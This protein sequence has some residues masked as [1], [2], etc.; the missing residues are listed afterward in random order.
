MFLSFG[1]RNVKV[2]N[3]GLKKWLREGRK[4]IP[5]RS[6]RSP[7]NSRP[8][9]IR[10]R[11]QQAAIARQSRNARRAGDRCARRERFE[12]TVPSRG[13]AFAPVTSRAAATCPTTNCSTPATGAMKPLD[14]LRQAFTGAGVEADKTDRDELRLRRLRAGADAGALS[15]RRARHRAL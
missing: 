4:V 10:L 11:P 3:G 14:D 9:S 7:E 15:A 13:R 2:L 8:S 1:H 12:G 5:A 6:R